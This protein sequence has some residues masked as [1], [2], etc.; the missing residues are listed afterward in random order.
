MANMLAASCVLSCAQSQPPPLHPFEQGRADLSPIQ[1]P[2]PNV[3]IPV[4][5]AT[6]NK[7]LSSPSQQSDD[8][9]GASIAMTLDTIVVGAPNTTGGG[10]AWIFDLTDSSAAPIKLIPPY[11]SANDA[12]GNSVAISDSGRFIAVGAP[13][14][15]VGDNINTGV[16][17][18]WEKKELK[19]MFVGTFSSENLSENSKLGSSVAIGDDTLLAGAPYAET[20]IPIEV[21]SITQPGMYST[22][23]KPVPAHGIV[24]TW[25]R[26]SQGHWKENISLEPDPFVENAQ[27]GGAMSLKGVQLMVSAASAHSSNLMEA[28][29]CYIFIRRVSGWVAEPLV[30]VAQ[31]QFLGI[32]NVMTGQGP[33]HHFGWSV[34]I[35]GTIALAGAPDDSDGQMIGSGS[36]S[37][38]ER[39]DLTWSQVQYVSAPD[40][41]SGD[42]FGSA[43][44]I[45]GTHFVVGAPLKSNQEQSRAG[46]VYVYQLIPGS[47]PSE[48]ELLCKLLPSLPKSNDR[49]GAIITCTPNIIAISA[50]GTTNPVATGHIYIFN[51][52]ENLWGVQS[53]ASNLAPNKAQNSEN[54]P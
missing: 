13:G 5:Q 46:V 35:L 42:A 45:A 18:V 34:H 23:Y 29:E 10:A 36:M 26:D 7:I 28:G 40:K 31:T 11:R 8:H 15:K 9:F 48:E 37:V 44:G 41:K 25:I 30:K 24:A 6:E 53:P 22:E 51:R 33:N 1:P 43:V 47:K 3:D 52:T 38:Y 17:H 12:C 49:F 16:V 27:F 4:V 32:Q 14:A 54:T 2:T 39:S 20:Y 19:W 21:E 50:P